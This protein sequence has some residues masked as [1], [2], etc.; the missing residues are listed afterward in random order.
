MTL[1]VHRGAKQIGGCVTEIASGQWRL[2]ID[3]GDNLPG[4][5]AALPPI[6]GL[7]FGDGSRSALFFTHYHSDHIGNLDKVMPGI[8]VYMGETAKAVQTT[9]AK[10]AR[11][12]KPTMFDV[13]KTFTPLDRKKIGNITV[14][15]LMIDH[16]AFDAYMF[17]IE[18]EGCRILH[19]GDFRLHGVRGSK[20]LKMLSYYAKN[21]HYIICEGTM[22]SRKGPPPMSEY[23][24]Q[25]KAKE[26]MKNAPTPY[27]FVL[28][29]STNIDRIA[30]FYHANPR[31]R[32][33]VCDKYQKEQLETIR[34]AHAGKS[35]FYDFKHVLS[36][37]PNLDR[38]MEER[39]FC[40]LVRKSAWK[41]RLLGPV[42]ESYKGK[43]LFVYSMW[44]GYLD[45]QA[46]DQELCDLL[47]PYREGQNRYA[48]LHTSGHAPPE[49]LRRLFQTVNP[50]LGLIPIH[51]ERPELF[52]DIIPK[53][54]L[55]LLDDGKEYSP[56]PFPE[57]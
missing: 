27:V 21:V 28:C 48:E 26:L 29:S 1:T 18:A 10:W 24:L 53:E 47:A 51:G 54:K 46:R 56:P 6:E 12:E 19:T 25:L 23:G 43:S 45:G 30:A 7:T 40:M 55:L 3:F 50:K 52:Q 31:G 16:S 20:T 5:D 35:G 15:P 39:G 9:V 17:L 13:V 2:F 33:F 41:N 38:L 44:T 4:N 22:L 36:Y 8:P 14:T 42:M 34:E 32:L 11:R 49:D 57:E 37:A